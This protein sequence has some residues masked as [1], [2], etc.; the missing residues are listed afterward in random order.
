MHRLNLAIKKVDTT[1]NQLSLS[2]HVTVNSVNGVN[3][4]MKASVCGFLAGKDSFIL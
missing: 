4:V 1:T 3:F 2:S